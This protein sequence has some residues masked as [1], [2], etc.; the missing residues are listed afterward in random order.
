MTTG[1]LIIFCGPSGVGK[2]SIR[3]GFNDE[4]SFNLDFS[5][6]AT[7]RAKRSN[8][9]DGEDYLFL[10]K[11][12]FNDWIKNDQFLEYAKFSNNFYGTP[13]SSIDEKLQTKN[14]LLEI[15]LDGVKQVLDKKSEDLFII[16]LLPPT[17]KELKKRLKNRSTE[18]FFSLRSRLKIAK[19]E[20]KEIKHFDAKFPNL[21]KKIN[22]IIND[23]EKQCVAAV[24]GIL[25]KELVKSD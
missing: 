1:K 20:I 11:E 23:T 21:E 3:K 16:F 7:T 9:T 13:I 22:I 10:T 25:E 24:R 8:E 2:G 4:Q 14:V 19:K 15:E 6:S 12:K 17:L 18:S 5:V